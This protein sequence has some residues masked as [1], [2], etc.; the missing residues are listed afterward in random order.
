MYE[1]IRW[2]K[3]IGNIG[4]ELIE[5]RESLNEKVMV[6]ETISRLVKKIDET[7]KS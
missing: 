4:N 6:Q 1:K 7:I 3:I 2:I 5:E